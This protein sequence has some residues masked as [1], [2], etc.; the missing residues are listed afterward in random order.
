MSTAATIV[1]ARADLSIPGAAEPASLGTDGPGA[2]RARF[3]ELIGRNNPDVIV[4]DFS[5]ARAGAIETIS[6]IRQKTEIPILILCSPEQLEMEEYRNA[7][8]ADCIAAPVDIGSLN[9]AIQR[10]V[11]V[12]G[13]GRLPLRR[14]SRRAA[15][16]VQRQSA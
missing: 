12:R 1:F 7:G 4:L 5:H 9:H 13:Q 10:V 15:A 2:V 16:S 3:F 14:A 11:Q 6:A 8:A